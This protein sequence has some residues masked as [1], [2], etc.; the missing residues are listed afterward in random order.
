MVAEKNIRLNGTLLGTFDNDYT[1]LRDRHHPSAN[2]LIV[3]GHS[4]PWQTLIHDGDDVLLFDAAT[5]PTP[6]LWRAIYDARYGRDIM[7]RLQAGRVAICGLGGLGSLVALELARLGVGRLLLIDG[8]RVDPTNL[9]RQHYSLSQIGQAKT[10]AMADTI[11][12][13]APLTTV[14][15][16][17]VWLNADNIV[18]L[19]DGWPL[20]CEC[21][22]RPESKAL[23]AE[24]VLRDLPQTT[25]ICASGMAGYRSGNAITAKRVLPRLYMIGDSESE[26]EEGIGLMAPRVG[27]CASAQATL[28]MR[29]LLGETTP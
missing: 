17:T 19:L 12:R 11:T 15:T 27:L 23:L 24:H 18:P 3:N 6:A 4:R 28:T 2:T 29:L 26:G 16:A 8:D 20:V 21:L 1:A 25:L 9:A 13:C 14:E 10:D 7:D 22:D 5:P